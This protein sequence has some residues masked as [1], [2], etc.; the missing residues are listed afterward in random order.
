MCKSDS[1]LL[2]SVG[3]SW[4]CDPRYSPKILTTRFEEYILP[5]PNATST[6]DSKVSKC[7]YNNTCYRYWNSGIWIFDEHFVLLVE[8]FKVMNKNRE[9]S[10]IC[11]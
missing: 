1:H 10:A 3:P 11:A 6:K 9:F 8:T 2:V 5:S 4:L 7:F